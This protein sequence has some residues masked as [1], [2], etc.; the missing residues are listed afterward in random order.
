VARALAGPICP[1]AKLPPD[2]ACADRP[3]VGAT[4]V[5]SGPAGAIVARAVTG[6]DGTFVI[7]VA[8]GA[9][10]LVPQPVEG[11]MGV[12]PPTTVVVEAGA[13]TRADLFYDTGI[14]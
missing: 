13:V 5:V 6:A 12:A 14:R 2:P 10:T 11:L 7:P 1:V 9:Y 4:V 8:P 3:V